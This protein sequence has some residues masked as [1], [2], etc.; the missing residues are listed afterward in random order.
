MSRARLGNALLLLACLPARRRFRR[1]RRDPEATQLAILR[2]YLRRNA[3]TAFGRRHRYAAIDSLAAFRDA[4]PVRSYDAFEPW[5]ERVRRGEPNVLTAEPVL[6]MEKTSGSSGPAKYVPYTASLRREFQ[7]AFGAWLADLYL[8]RPAL[9]GGPHYWS[10]SPL[11]RAKETTPGGLPVGFD[12]DAE[13]LGTLARRVLRWVM[14]VP[15]EVGR[16]AT[17]EESR[18]ATLRHLLQARE[19]RLISVWSPSFL[20]L[21]MAR[22]PAGAASRELWPRLA[23][24]SCWTS[25]AA[26]RAVPGVEELFPGVEIQ[27]KGLLSTE[28][29]VSIPEIGRPAPAPAWTSHFL[30]FVDEDGRPRLAGELEVGRRYRVVLT[31]GGGLAR[32]ATGDLVDAVAPGALEFAG[33]DQVS[34]LAGEKLSEGFVAAVLEETARRFAFSGFLM[35]APEWGSPPR[36]LLLAESEDAEAL[37]GAVED[38]LRA[39]VHYDYCRRLGQLAAVA[40]VAVRGAQERYL[41]ACVALGQ[42]AGDVKPAY[43]RRDLGWREHLAG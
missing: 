29:V 19:L 7:N 12:D 38:G 25:A 23:L 26:A 20:T 31:T 4:V 9:L 37:A 22:L 18:Q 36:Y 41:E 35:L 43:L 28:G 8:R 6:M 21:L 14:A 2:S 34:D 11:A 15:G 17:V 42:R 16:A 40:G 13:Y 30:E 33:R 1:A 10:I 5:I 3:G 24:V 32:Y 39:S 27:G